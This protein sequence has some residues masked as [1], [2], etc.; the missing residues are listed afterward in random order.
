MVGIS[1]DL[2]LHTLSL[3]FARPL[4]IGAYAHVH[5]HTHTGALFPQTAAP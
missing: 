2:K 4:P 5:T 3:T 1:Q